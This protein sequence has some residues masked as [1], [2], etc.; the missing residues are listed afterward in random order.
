M[1]SG[2]RGSLRGDGPTPAPL[3]MKAGDIADIHGQ[4]QAKRAMETAAAGRHDLLKTAPPGSGKALLARAM[5]SILP[6]L[7]QPR[8]WKRRNRVKGHRLS[9][10][11][12]F[13]CS[14]NEYSRFTKQ[15]CVSIGPLAHVGESQSHQG[16][17]GRWFMEPTLRVGLAGLGSV[18]RT[19]LYNIQ[20][21]ENVQ[22]TAVA[23]VRQSRASVSLGST[24]PGRLFASQLARYRYRVPVAPQQLASRLARSDERHQVVHLLLFHGILPCVPGVDDDKGNLPLVSEGGNLLDSELILSS[25]SRP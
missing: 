15:D 18:S 20:T 19:I 17:C 13:S 5:A 22:L 10:V 1:N 3:P 25:R 24:E 8:P 16:A 4:D 12:S 9:G 23:D 6:P 11:G 21:I 14:V 7:T 2:R